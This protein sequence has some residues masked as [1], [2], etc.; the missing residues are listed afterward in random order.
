M[1]RTTTELAPDVVAAAT[2]PTLAR[3]ED[4]E[5]LARHAGVV[6]TSPRRYHR[7]SAAYPANLVAALSV[8]LAD[9]RQSRP[10]GSTGCPDNAAIPLI[11]V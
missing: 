8:L 2:E 9:H 10:T 6:F 4:E 7:G 11:A 1:D 5:L 3:L